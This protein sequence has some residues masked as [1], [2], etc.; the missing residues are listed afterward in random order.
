MGFAMK[1]L[2]TI[3]ILKE[4]FVYKWLKCGSIV[5]TLWPHSLSLE[6]M[7]ACRQF[8]M[9]WKEHIRNALIFKVGDIRYKF[10][11]N[12]NFFFGWAVIQPFCH[13]Q[14]VFNFTHYHI[15][16]CVGSSHF[17][18]LRGWSIQQKLISIM[19][20]VLTQEVLS[21]R[22]FRRLCTMGEEFSKV[23]GL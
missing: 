20:H 18:I 3:F 6:L 23:A 14:L 2:R 16:F 5:R 22:E 11:S 12:L 13:L 19:H 10:Q 7:S 21:R 15:R 17:K 4:L 9:N 8:T 1:K